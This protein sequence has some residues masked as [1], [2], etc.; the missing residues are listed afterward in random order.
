M[1]SQLHH[2]STPKTTTMKTTS[3]LILASCLLLGSAV[4]ARTI[5]WGTETDS[6][7]IDSNGTTLDADYTFEL[8]TFG[9]FVPTATNMDQWLTNWKVFD[10]AVAPT[11]Y[12]VEFGWVSNSA[13]L[14]AD[15]TSSRSDLPQHTFNVGEQAYI[16]V[17]D[18]LALGQ[19]NTEVALVTDSTW[20]MPTSDT[21][22]PDTRD[23][24]INAAGNAVYGGLNDVQGPGAHSANPTA[25]VLQTHT[26]AAPVP[27]PS[28]AMLLT[29]AGLMM[30]RRRR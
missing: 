25:F 27:E 28:S 23:W 21:H 6:I 29:L 20:L 1:I 15:M 11:D 5:A 16:M 3:L 7:L 9:T 18:S 13:T 2:H 24:R 19:A 4:Q 12:N 8:G 26:T 14:E 30:R 10:R 17:Y 22:S